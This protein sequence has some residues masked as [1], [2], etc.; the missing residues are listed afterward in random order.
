MDSLVPRLPT[1]ARETIHR[2]LRAH[3]REA[4]AKG[5]VIGSSGGIDSA[6]VLRLSKDALGPSRVW[7]VSIPD[8]R[9]PPALRAE[10]ADYARDLRVGFSEVELAPLEIPFLPLLETDDRVARG[11]LKARLR[12]VVW[13][14]EARRRGALVAG[15]GNKSELLLGYFTK[16]GDGGVDLLPIGDLYKTSVWDLAAELELPKSVRERAPTAGLW[17]GQTDEEELGMPY[18]MLDQILFGLERLLEPEEIARATGVPLDRVEAIVGRV[19]TFRHKRRP[20]PI[21]KLMLR[22]LGLDW[23]D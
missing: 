6:L 3:V 12:M 13:Y 20:P 23:R 10:V 11:N 7:A 14:Q 1:H 18:A 5:V 21:P 2:F 8:E 15:T 17:E 19:R 16:Y 22:T 9:T 4:G